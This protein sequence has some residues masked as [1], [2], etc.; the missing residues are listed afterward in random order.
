VTGT[1][2]PTA[3]RTP[4]STAGGTPAL[5]NPTATATPIVSRGCADEPLPGCRRQV[6]AAKGLL[7]IKDGTPDTKDTLVWR[8][9][10]GAVTTKG[11]FG[12][13]LSSTSYQLC[14]Y[15]ADFDVVVDAAIAAGGLCGSTR[16]KPC[17]KATKKGLKYR[18]PG[19]A[20]DGIT[21][22]DLKEGLVDG[23]T[24]ITLAGKGPLLDDPEIPLLQPILVQLSNS[25]GLCW[26]ARYSD[27]A[28]SNAIGRSSSLFKDQA[29]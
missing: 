20:A 16:P 19:G 7:T 3:T 12:A 10:K 17:W 14:V 24:A 21:S 28:K 11:E 25:D 8:W 4:T 26:E 18:S 29:D 6:V 5:A 15:D 23:K 27:P 9:A 2:G 1:A 13:P 22:L